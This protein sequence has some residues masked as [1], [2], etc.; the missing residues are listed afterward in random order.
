MMVS[1]TS[2]MPNQL[3]GRTCPATFVEGKSIFVY[4]TVHGNPQ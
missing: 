3:I 1:L 4:G 2:D